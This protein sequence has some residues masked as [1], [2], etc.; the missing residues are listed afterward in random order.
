[1]FLLQGVQHRQQGAG[2]HDGQAQEIAAGQLFM[3][4]Q[5]GQQGAQKRRQRIE[6]AGPGGADAVLGADIGED[7]QAVGG[8]AQA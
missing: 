5:E 3:Q 8:K 2:D 6:G 4:E 7:A 1:M